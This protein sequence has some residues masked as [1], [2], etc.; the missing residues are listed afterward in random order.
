[1]QKGIAEDSFERAQKEMATARYEHMIRYFL[2]R[3][4]PDDPRDKHEFEADLF[5]IVRQVMMD[6]QEPMMKQM[7]ALALAHAQP[8]VLTGNKP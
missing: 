7:S 6:V 1:M 5:V 8:L 2:D 3:Y 4:A